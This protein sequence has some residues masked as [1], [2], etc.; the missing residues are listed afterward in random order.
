MLEER[1]KARR[2]YLDKQRIEQFKETMKAKAEHQYKIDL[3]RK[4]QEN[5]L[6]E[7]KLLFEHKQKANEEKTP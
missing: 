3:T 7:Q 4:K 2:D 5:K 1:E 6:H